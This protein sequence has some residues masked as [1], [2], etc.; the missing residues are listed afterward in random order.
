MNQGKS[1]AV[2]ILISEEGKVCNEATYR[3]TH[4]KV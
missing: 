1:S 2:L 4:I 3:E